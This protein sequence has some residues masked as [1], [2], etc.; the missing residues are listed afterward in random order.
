MKAVGLLDVMAEQP[1]VPE[2]LLVAERLWRRAQVARKPLAR[3]GIKPSGPTWPGPL[4][5]PGQSAS[6]ESSK[7][8]LHRAGTLAKVVGHFV[9]TESRTAQQHA[10]E[11][12]VIPRLL[13]TVNLLLHGNPH[14]VCIAYFQSAHGVL[15]SA[16]S[17]AERSNMRN[18][19]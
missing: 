18:Y 2:G 4:L 16:H 14:D 1:A 8:M 7:P 6:L 17:I 3:G 19:L 11:P 5:K 9:A 13:R 15:L 12:V 10:V